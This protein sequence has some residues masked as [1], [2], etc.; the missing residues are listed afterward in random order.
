MDIKQLVGWIIVIGAI[1]WGLV[2]LLGVNLVEM[3]F[4]AGQLLSKVVYI[5]IGFAGVFAAYNMVGGK[6]K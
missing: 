4:G 3:I 5:I 6:K 1:N 2:G